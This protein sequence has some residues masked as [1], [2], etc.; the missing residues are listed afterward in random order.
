MGKGGLEGSATGPRI[1]SRDYLPKYVPIMTPIQL[2]IAIFT[3]NRR[4]DQQNFRI[5]N[6]RSKHKNL[7]FVRVQINVTV[8]TVVV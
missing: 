3:V 1:S 2:A 6:I 7:L 8:Q 4:S 5:G